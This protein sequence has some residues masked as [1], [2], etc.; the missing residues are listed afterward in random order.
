MSRPRP[1]LLKST[2]GASVRLGSSNSTPPWTSKRRRMRLPSPVSNVWTVSDPSVLSVAERR[3][4]IAV[5]IL[6]TD[7]AVASVGYKINTIASRFSSSSVDRVRLRSVSRDRATALRHSPG[8]AADVLGHVHIMFSSHCFRAI[9]SARQKGLSHSTSMASGQAWSPCSPV[10][11]PRYSLNALAAHSVG[12]GRATISTSLPLM[13]R[14]TVSSR[15]SF[16]NSG[17]EQKLPPRL[18]D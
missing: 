13:N 4:I 1:P 3:R 11:L 18:V 17:S 6:R 12:R 16:E 5:R 7:V 9:P 10:R 2:G 8:A 14:S 15:G